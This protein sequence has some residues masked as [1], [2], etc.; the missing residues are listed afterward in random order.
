MCLHVRVHVCSKSLFYSHLC[1]LLL[2]STPT[3]RY[4]L[5]LELLRL[6]WVCRSRISSS[7]HRFI[8]LMF[9]SRVNIYA[10]ASH[11]IKT[12][13]SII[14]SMS[15]KKRR[16]YYLLAAHGLVITV[17]SCRKLIYDL[18]RTNKKSRDIDPNCLLIYKWAAQAT[19][20]K[21][22]IGFFPPV[23]TGS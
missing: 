20:S 19:K 13:M 11:E 3:I 15:Q 16:I 10:I 12:P 9:Q 21:H 7:S 5:R 17:W 4:Q 6:P 18:K 8:F 1:S 22:H 23:A 14:C 2:Q